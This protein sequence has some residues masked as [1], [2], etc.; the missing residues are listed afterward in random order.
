MLARSIGLFRGKEGEEPVKA[1]E[2]HPARFPAPS[3]AHLF[4]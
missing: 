2:G 1:G 3:P 4:D